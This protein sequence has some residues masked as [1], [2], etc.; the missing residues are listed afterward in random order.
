MAEPNLRVVEKDGMDRSEAEKSKALEAALSQIERSH[1]K[2]S[3]MKLGSAWSQLMKWLVNFAKTAVY[4]RNS[5]LPNL[6]HCTI[7]TLVRFTIKQ[8]FDKFFSLTIISCE[9]R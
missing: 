2:G 6:T 9:L 8:F 7:F 5:T 1:G 4:Q 3:I